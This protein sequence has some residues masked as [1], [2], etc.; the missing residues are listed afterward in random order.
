MRLWCRLA[1]FSAAAVLA[2]SACGG[3]AASPASGPPHD[4]VHYRWA[5]GDCLAAASRDALPHEPFGARLIVDCDEAHTFEVFHAGEIEAGDGAPYPDDLVARTSETCA[6][7]FLDYVG[8]HLSET[9]LDMMVYRPDRSEWAGGLRYETCLVEDRRPG[10]DPSPVAGSLRGAG[11]RVPST[12]AAGQ[13]FEARSVLGPAVACS[14]PHLAEAIGVF[15]HPDEIGAMWPGVEEMHAA[16]N[17]GCAVL[18]DEYATSGDPAVTVTP[19]GFTRPL[20]RPEWDDGLR[21]VACGALVFD[22]DNRHVEVVGSLSEPDWQ[23]VSAAQ[24]A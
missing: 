1:A 9:S 4:D 13:C 15:V 12:V 18:L 24:V 21:T 14:E 16:A 7:A 19:I 23:I 5:V 11:D 17:T 20:A 10:G 3:E 2:I 6:A 8:A 22:S